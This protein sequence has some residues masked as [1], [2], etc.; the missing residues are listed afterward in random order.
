MTGKKREGNILKV[1]PDGLAVALRFKFLAH[2]LLM[3]ALLHP[4][5]QEFI[6]TIAGQIGQPGP[7]TMFWLKSLPAIAV[8]ARGFYMY[9]YQRTCEFELTDER[10]IVRYGLIMRV[11]DEIELYRIVDVTQ[12]VG[13]FQRVIGV[14][15]VY[16]SSTD[17]TGAVFI[18]LVRNSAAIRNAV[19]DAAE[20]CKNRRGALRILS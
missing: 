4:R 17:R 6:E 11:E 10:L 9:L 3:A 16:V 15:N 12:T 8:F 1:R 20:E 14:G 7:D 5:T 2:V 13:I 19:R 18:P